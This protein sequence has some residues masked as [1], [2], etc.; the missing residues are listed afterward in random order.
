MLCGGYESQGEKVSHLESL[1][2]HR[3]HALVR[4]Q[5]G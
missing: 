4:T 2:H 1:A 3:V 5:A